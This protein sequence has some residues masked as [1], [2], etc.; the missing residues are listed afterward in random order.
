[1]KGEMNPTSRQQILFLS[2]APTATVVWYLVVH[3]TGYRKQTL[4]SRT[5]GLRPRRISKLVRGD[6]PHTARRHSTHARTNHHTPPPF[7]RS[8]APLAVTALRLVAALVAVSAAGALLPP[9]PAT[10]GFSLVFEDDF[11]GENGSPPNPAVYNV[12]D[13][14]VHTQFDIACFTAANAYVENGNLVLRTRAEHVTCDG[15]GFEYTS[16]W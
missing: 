8:P 9:L 12:A 15:R 10:P 4:S 1:M 16:G 13:G 11:L 14:Y 3:P 7:R 5:R 2:S 6:T